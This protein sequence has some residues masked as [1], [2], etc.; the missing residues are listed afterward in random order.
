MLRPHWSKGY[1]T[2]YTHTQN[3]IDRQ[4]DFNKFY[5]F[6]VCASGT[7]ST[8]P[9]DS[10]SFWPISITIQLFLCISLIFKWLS[11]FFYPVIII[12]V[13]CCVFRS[14]YFCCC[15]L[16]QREKTRHK[17]GTKPFAFPSCFILVDIFWHTLPAHIFR[18]Y[19]FTSTVL[20]DKDLFVSTS[21]L[22]LAFLGYC[23]II[24]KVVLNLFYEQ[25]IFRR[26]FFFLSNK[27]TVSSYRLDLLIS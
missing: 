21:F 4:L 22:V 6:C 1:T 8:H 27:S 2:D 18:L 24:A 15:G 5:I 13:A 25:Q 23:F 20:S 9:I 11:V 7:M 14:I 3:V 16:R 26:Q 12:T 19:P 17:T 10:P